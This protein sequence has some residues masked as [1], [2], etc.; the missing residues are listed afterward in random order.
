LSYLT[1]ISGIA[2]GGYVDVTGGSVG[3]YASGNVSLGVGAV[4]TA[5]PQGS[6]FSSL[7]SFKGLGVG[8]EI[9]T[10]PVAAMVT[11]PATD[12]KSGWVATV[13]GPGDS[14]FAGVPLTYTKTYELFN[15]RKTWAS[16]VKKA[17]ALAGACPK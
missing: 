1:G 5:G 7:D 12:P 9:D 14:L 4:L 13:A 17:R 10:L 6:L 2:G 16:L 3:L 15:W 8:A 11:V